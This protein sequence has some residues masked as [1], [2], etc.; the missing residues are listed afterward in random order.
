MKL[1]FLDING[2]CMAD[3]MRLRDKLEISLNALGIEIEDQPSALSPQK[4]EEYNISALTTAL[5]GNLGGESRPGRTDNDVSS[6]S[7]ILSARN[8]HHCYKIEACKAILATTNPAFTSTVD[9]L[10]RSKLAGEIR[11]VIDDIDLTAL[12]WLRSWDAKST[13]PTDILLDNAYAAC[14]PSTS[15]MDEFTRTVARLQKEDKITEEEA[16][17][18]RTQAAPRE[19]LLSE[20]ENDTA[21]VTD[22][23]VIK[24]RDK[25]AMSLTERKDT[26]I[27]SLTTELD[28]ERK[29][30]FAAIAKA[31]ELAVQK[32][33]KTVLA[34]RIIS[35]VVF[36]SLLATAAIALIISNVALDAST[37]LKIVLVFIGILG[38]VDSLKSRSGW[39][40]KLISRA[41]NKRFDTVYGSELK[42]IEQYFE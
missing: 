37:F 7:A 9:A 1:E 31:E 23:L 33:E 3:V 24:I 13:L 38:F 6:I 36:V 20:T 2:Y 19:D 10:Y 5:Q 40:S 41:G 15:L 35:I 22:N 34:L 32:K 39:V 26:E 14:M 8:G 27:G 21:S 42:R 25:Y 28:R 16:L 11:L 29:K 17:L 30:K 4:Q 12:L 18:L